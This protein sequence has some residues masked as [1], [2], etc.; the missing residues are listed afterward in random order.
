MNKY[1]TS[2]YHVITFDGMGSK[3]DTT[4]GFGSLSDAQEAAEQMMQQEH[5][6]SYAVLRV[7]VNSAQTSN[8][9]TATGGTAARLAT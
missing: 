8:K 2:S 3:I 1:Q 4:V 9:W 6:A 7:I 5:A